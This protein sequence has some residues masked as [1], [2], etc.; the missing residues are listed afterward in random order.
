MKR[1]FDRVE[2][3]KAEYRR[4]K[5]DWNQVGDR[6]FELQRMQNQSSPSSSATRR[7]S[8]RR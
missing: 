7:C 8:P 1:F 4:V 2:E 3:A 6:I 5:G